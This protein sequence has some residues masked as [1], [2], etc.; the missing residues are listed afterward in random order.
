MI[1]EIVIWAISN[2]ENERNTPAAMTSHIISCLDLLSAN[3]DGLAAAAAPYAAKFRLLQHLYATLNAAAFD[4]RVRFVMI[5][6][7][8]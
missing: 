2:K 6:N 3:Y 5:I 8:N 1:A 7:D 4:E